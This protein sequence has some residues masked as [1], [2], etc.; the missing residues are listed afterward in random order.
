MISDMR[1]KAL[2]ILIAMIFVGSSLS[3]PAF[4]AVKAGASCKNKGQVMTV[5]GLKYTCTKSGN[6]LVWGKS[7][8]VTPTPSISSKLISGPTDFSDLYEKR[9]GISTAL[10]T[11]IT[12]KLSSR[13]QIPPIEVYRGPNTPVHVKDPSEYFKFVA[14][15]FS[16]KPLPKKI[17]VFYWTNSDMEAVATKAL[18][19]M[20]TENDQKHRLETT[21]PFVDCYSPTSC[22]VGHAFIG[23]DGIAYLGLGIPDTLEEAKKTAGGLGGVEV[24]EF[25]HSLNLLP[26]HLNSVSVVAPKQNTKSPL[27]PPFW[28]KQGSENVMSMSL[29][30]K[31]DLTSFKQM[32]GRK[33]WVNQVIPDFGPDW[34]NNYLD[35]S[36]LGNQWSD[37]SFKNSKPHLIM[38]MY[39]IEIFGALKGPSVMLD[40]FE[41]MSQKKSFTDVFQNTFGI[42]WNEAKPE[43]ARVINDRYL[44][45]Y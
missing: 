44:N 22:D 13:V 39:L 36:N 18:A 23:N 27:Q 5:S 12:A 43:L 21:G 28:Y 1:K 20:G 41:Q 45:N 30:H 6:K 10:W 26:Y 17:V 3:T 33:A 14:Q 37:S 9:R 15:V 38:G 34:I 40:F 24:V 4:A 29:T 42:T 8:K 16:G 7:I 19:V 11:K 2:A 35:I 31:N 32:S 25:Y